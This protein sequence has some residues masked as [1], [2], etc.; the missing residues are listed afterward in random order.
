M[1]DFETKTIDIFAASDNW[2]P[3][4]FSLP[5]NSAQSAADGA[6]PYG[7]TISS[8]VIKVFAGQVKSDADFATLTNIA[9]NVLD[10]DYPAVINNESVELRFKHPGAS[11]VNT[12]A[13][14]VF[15]LTLSNGAVH[16]FF[17][18]YLAFK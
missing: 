16:P 13:T 17:F 18:H 9:S 5:A 15:I 2:G 14:V 7:A 10:P 11:Y 1:S 8:A 4:K 3:Y 12:K 6:I